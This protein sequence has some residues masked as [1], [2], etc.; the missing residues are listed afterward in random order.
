MD[1]GKRNEILRKI[2]QRLIAISPYVLIWQSDRNRLL[3]WNRFGTP[4][5]V[6]DKFNREDSVLTYWWFDA[7]KSAELDAAR[8]SDKALPALPSEVHY[9]E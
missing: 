6:L 8:S 9:A 7:K 1:L 5:Q 4:K 2:D 3:Y